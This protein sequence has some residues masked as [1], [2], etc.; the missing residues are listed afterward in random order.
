M[1]Q[2]LWE[3][4][5]Q[6][7]NHFFLWIGKNSSAH[8]TKLLLFWH[9]FLFLFSFPTPYF[10]EMFPAQLYMLTLC[11]LSWQW[12]NVVAK[13][14]CAIMQLKQI[15]EW[16][17]V[18]VPLLSFLHRSCVN[19]YKNTE[20]SNG[21]WFCLHQFYD[22]ENI[23]CLTDVRNWYMAIHLKLQVTCIPPGLATTVKYCFS[24]NVALC[25]LSSVKDFVNV[26]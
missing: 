9:A 21:I 12:S 15:P 2:L 25:C 1:E 14:F 11:K 3:K 19:T 24:H 4:N 5:P 18:C 20:S 10:P 22:E 6:K 8:N 7:N 16:C 23:W 26:W 13:L 17:R